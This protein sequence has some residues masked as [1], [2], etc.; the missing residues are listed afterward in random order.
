[1]TRTT[2]LGCA[3]LGAILPFACGGG[4]VGAVEHASRSDSGVN[5]LP[6]Q[7]E[8][9]ADAGA[10]EGT[11]EPRYISLLIGIGSYQHDYF[12]T[13]EGDGPGRFASRLSGTT[14]DV[15]RVQEALRGWGFNEGPDQQ[16]LLDRQ[17]TK[18]GIADAFRWLRERANQSDDVVVIY[19]SGH[20]SWAPDRDFGDGVR[21]LDEDTAYPYD[22]A[23]VPWD[24]RHMNDPAHLVLDDE[25]ND[26][27]RQ[28]PTSNITVILD[29]CHSGTGTRGEG[30]EYPRARGPLSPPT[31]GRLPPGGLFS[32]AQSG[33]GGE[34]G[35]NHTLLSAAAPWELAW[36]EP[37]PEGYV[38]GAFTYHLTQVLANARRGSTTYDDVIRQVHA[39]LGVAKQ[40][41]QLEGDASALLFRVHAGAPQRSYAVVTP[42][43]DGTVRLDVGGIHGARTAAVYDV[44]DPQEMSFVGTA[45]AQV[46]VDAVDSTTSTAAVLS[47]RVP[48]GGRAVLARVPHGAVT[49]ERL[50]LY[51]D[52]SASAA[53]DSLA[54]YHEW[55]ELAE[56]Q[57]A[58]HA[59]VRKRGQLFEVLVSGE[60]VAPL[61]SDYERGRAGGDLERPGVPRGYY[62][63]RDALCRP[64]QRA[65]AIMGLRLLQNSREDIRV[66][67][68]ALPSG[69]TPPTQ[70]S[71]LTAAD[72]VYVDSLVTVWAWIWADEAAVRQT[73]VYLSAAIS[74]F[75]A[76]PIS[77]WPRGS[78]PA[79]ALNPDQ[80]NRPI[81][82]MAGIR[83]SPVTGI[84]ILKAYAGVERF[85]F[86]AFIARLPDCGDVRKGETTRGDTWTTEDPRIEGWSTAERR[87]EILRR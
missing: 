12:V 70:P 32:T 63:T 47:G 13:G 50:K 69:V 65:Y 61:G 68:R 26:W 81:P 49:L 36:E 29:A 38:F 21:T 24:T 84:E 46:R 6:G 34:A 44:Y 79:I 54:G 41:P 39:R 43:R 5:G 56:S 83:M 72:T 58:A 51:L 64:L 42:Q 23:L 31:A 80:V 19:Y 15:L 62:N 27:L 9:V 85:D 86:R 25:I 3:L 57:S 48:E 78:A 11:R 53:R 82:V 30:G 74:G 59:V 14:N 18:Q 87:V 20:G 2:I 22:Q 17:A 73:P 45:A 16:K 55:I 8:S 4:G 76:Q 52:P 66:D 35:L 77:L 75:T 71:I 67:I 28:I 1:M 40:T 10:K 7:A 33:A 60:L 37:T